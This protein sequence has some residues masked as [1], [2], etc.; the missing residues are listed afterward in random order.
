[1][2]TKIGLQDELYSKGFFMTISEYGGL[3]EL[4]VVFMTYTY[5]NRHF[6]LG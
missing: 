4:Y 3:L 5:W 1:M 6:K 2:N